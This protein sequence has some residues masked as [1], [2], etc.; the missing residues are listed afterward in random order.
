M[1]LKNTYIT[2][3]FSFCSCSLFSQNEDSF[4]YNQFKLCFEDISKQSDINE[5]LIPNNTFTKFLYGADN[6]QKIYGRTKITYPNGCDFFILRQIIDY[7]DLEIE[8]INNLFYLIFHKE[9]LVGEYDPNDLSRV[10][11]TTIYSDGGD[12]IQSFELDKD[13][14]ILVLFYHKDCCSST[15][16][17]T[18]IETKTKV[19]F[20][21][22]SAGQLD[23]QEVI[24]VQFSSPF[25]DKAFLNK[26]KGNTFFKYPTQD[27]DH[28]LVCENMIR[29]IPLS[30]DNLQV[31]FY[32]DSINDTL[33][34]VFIIYDNNKTVGRYLDLKDILNTLDIGIESNLDLF[35]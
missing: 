24:E 12:L 33:Y 25:F 28:N 15:G 17:D 8:N 32:I 26:N 16:F 22:G 21:V 10:L 4:N 35:E 29:K 5:R 6:E 31:H 3:I 30:K 13:S 34:P 9:K 14:S 2:V 1:N 20:T 11:E 7:D 19:R 23:I 18:P 27:N